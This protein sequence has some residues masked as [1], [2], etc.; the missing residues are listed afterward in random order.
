MYRRIQIITII[1]SILA[2][3]VGGVWLLVSNQTP[4]PATPI[5]EIVTDRSITDGE[6]QLATYEHGGVIQEF[7]NPQYKIAFS[8]RR[9]TGAICAVFTGPVTVNETEIMVGDLQ[10]DGTSCTDPALAEVEA[11]L[12]AFS[13]QTLSYSINEAGDMLTLALLSGSRFTF[14]HGN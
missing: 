2:V 14:R 4:V 13:Q 1:T 5:S 9:I 7:K 12:T 10:V 11:A 3:A 6:W 8:S